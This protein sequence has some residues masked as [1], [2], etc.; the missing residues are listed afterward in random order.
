MIE[1]EAKRNRSDPEPVG[2]AGPAPPPV[3]DKAAKT[4]RR[5]GRWRRRL[6]WCG[7]IFLLFIVIFRLSLPWLLPWTLK[8]IAADYDL[9]CKYD[10]LELS[11]LGGDAE[12]WHLTVAPKEGGAPFIHAEYCRADIATPHLLAGRVIVRRLEA[13]G[14]D[15]LVERDEDGSIAL[16]KR[17]ENAAKKRGK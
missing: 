3:A 17:I 9:D 15:L 13:D 1:D 16:L 14:V 4:A 10:R 11:L 5:P 12:L 6:L 8:K 2:A 7:A